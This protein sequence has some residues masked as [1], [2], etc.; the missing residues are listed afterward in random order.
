MDKQ[1][2]DTAQRAANAISKGDKYDWFDDFY[3][4]ANGDQ[5]V[6]PWADTVA[7]PYLVTWLDRTNTSGEGKSA[8]VIG[9]GLGDDAEELA[10]RGFSVTA[11]DVSKNAVEWAMERFSNSPVQYLTSDLFAPDPSWKRGFDFVLECY[12]VQALPRDIR[13]RAIEAV[14]D[15]LAPKGT[16]LVIARG[17]APDQTEDTFPWAITDEDLALFGKELHESSK[18]DFIEKETNRRRLV[19]SYQKD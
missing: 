11:F 3:A 8:I 7:N 9:C 14:T 10:R 13:S 2:L 19:C 15:L 6:I 16:L 5:S 1:I 18:E 12:T 4:A 17:W